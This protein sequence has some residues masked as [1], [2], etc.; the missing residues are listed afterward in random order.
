MDK[1]KLKRLCI[2]LFF[3][4]GISVIM[5]AQNRITLNCNKNSLREVMEMIQKQTSLSFAFTDNIDA[6]KITISTSVNNADL[7]ATLKLILKPY[8]ITF[9]IV[10]KQIILNPIKGNDPNDE[11][12]IMV[13]GV[14][15]DNTGEFIPGV[16][17]KDLLSNTY[18]I[19]GANG[20]YEI[21]VSPKGKLTFF[22]MGMIDQTI[23]IAGKNIVNVTM[24]Q[25]VQVL[26]DIIVTGYQTI[27]KERSAASFSII[28]GDNVKNSA[29]ARGSILESLEG[30]AA[31]LTINMDK[32]AESK[33]SVRGITSVYSSKEPLF[34][35]D[36][37]AVSSD[38]IE[39]LLSPNDIASI[40]VLKD[41]T[42]VSIWG[43]RAANGVIVI[44]TK[45]GENTKG[46]INIHYDGSFTYKGKADLSKYNLMDSKTFIKNA[47][48]LFENPVYQQAYSW[49]LIS[50]GTSGLPYN[51]FLTPVV[52]PHEQI[53]Y[54][55]Q[56]GLI[57]RDERDSQL[58]TLESQDGY[59]CYQ[60]VLMTN[61][62]N[63][64]HN[65]SI[66]G[67]TER[68]RIFGSIG[69]ENSQGNFHDINNV[70]KMNLKQQFNVSKWLDWDLTLNVSH[71]DNKGHTEFTNMVSYGNPFVD[72]LPYAMIKNS[73]G[74]WSDYNNYQMYSPYRQKIE[75]DLGI[76]TKFSPVEDF[77]S[78]FN[79]SQ[80]TR[81]R[82]NT[83]L[84]AKIWNGLKY[85]VRLQYLRNSYNME[86]YIPMETW[87]IRKERISATTRGLKQILPVQGG[88]YEVKDS[89]T[90]DWTVRNQMTYNS[91]FDNTNHQITALAGIEYRENTIKGYNSFERGYDYQSMTNTNYDKT[92]AN[93]YF[94]NY[95]G[96]FV[97]VKTDNSSQTES[98]FRYISY[99][100]NLAYTF[101]NRYSFNGSI[102]IDQSNLFGTSVNNQYKPIGSVGVSWKLKDE[103]FIKDVKWVNNLTLR[104]SWGHSGNSPSPGFGGPYDIVDVYTGGSSF[105]NKNGYVISSPSNKMIGWEKT[106]IWNIGADFALINHRISGSIDLY[107][108][109]TSDL[110][111]EKALN[112]LTGYSTIFANVGSMSNKG[113]EININ[114]QNIVKKHFEWRSNI[115]LSHNRNEITDIY[116]TQ[117]T[118]IWEKTY[119]GKYSKGYPVGAIWGLKWSGL[120]HED[121][122]PQVYNK[123][124]DVCHVFSQ[125]SAE[126]LHYIGTTVPKVSGAFRNTISYQN[127]DLSAMLVFNLG[128]KIAI[129]DNNLVYKGRLYYNRPS[130][131]DE[132]WREPG[133]EENTFIPSAYEDPYYSGRSSWGT[134]SIMEYSDVRYQSGSYLKMRELSL[135]YKLPK[136]L[137]DNI[138]IEAAKITATGHDIA[139]VV[140]NNRRIDPEIGLGG[141]NI[142][143]YYSIGLNINF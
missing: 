7:N 118:S 140:A 105:D 106:R 139:K 109:K 1:S 42:A 44:T 111:S 83:S 78:N 103:G 101:L 57:S 34:V 96:N 100:G 40:T 114:T 69:F 76:S 8:G 11:E 39:N 143:A 113:I 77:Y 95:L 29:M 28:K 88:D 48:E 47:I 73:D 97:M 87:Y 122:A 93:Q 128:H 120:R 130:I 50:N 36:G 5:N 19:S 24:L 55:W 49:D 45:V 43:S 99:Y 70:Y 67:G 123:D 14:I 132:R 137:C 142:G 25:D 133:D 38:D 68:F 21:S 3:V 9:K 33:F 74:G 23:A 17:V 18:V 136:A 22:S 53:L 116:S 104:A 119:Y 32:N 90:S 6:D 31:G 63:Q 84:T 30:G 37:V 51:S 75:N 27:S 134:E 60:D 65:I 129:Y 117:T 26:E 13:K 92:A 80:D 141:D 79:R 94:S 15:I 135:S 46:K 85:E 112:I 107:S 71:A 115:T 125:L 138:G 20:E 110:L 62:W 12:K 10:G 61:L 41:A 124:G 81:V 59:K 52:F 58:N 4:F 66:N 72:M 64:I 16:V 82:A 102:R 54:D 35:L 56:R 126:D 131:F 98:K 86:N 2:S 127:F 89:F 108:K 121:G 91:S